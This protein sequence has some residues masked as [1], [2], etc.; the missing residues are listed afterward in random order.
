MDQVNWL[1]SG[2]LKL[3]TTRLLDPRVTVTFST[4]LGVWAE[5][6]SGTGTW[7]G[8]CPWAWLVLGASEQRD[9]EE[10]WNLSGIF[11]KGNRLKLF[12]VP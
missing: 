8:M 1:P 10:G 9:D 11:R 3:T 2:S 7:D 4:G 6:F 5:S 12:R